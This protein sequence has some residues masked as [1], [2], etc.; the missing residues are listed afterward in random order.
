[1][2][3]MT[4]GM[5]AGAGSSLLSGFL[6]SRSNRRAARM[7]DRF[8]PEQVSTA[9]YDELYNRVAGANFDQPLYEGFQSSQ[10]GAANQ[11]RRMYAQMGNP[12]L[13][14]EATA[15]ERRSAQGALFGALGQSNIQRLGMLGNIQAART[16]IESQNVQ[17][18]NAARMNALNFRAGMAQNSPWAQAAGAL[19]GMAVGFGAQ[20]SGQQMMQAQR[21]ED[22]AFLERM[23]GQQ[24]PQ[25]LAPQMNFNPA[26]SSMAPNTTNMYYSAGAPYG[27]P[28]TS[29]N[30]G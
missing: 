4:I 24:R 10:R 18:R 1:M 27:I 23:F 19:G 16:G 14:A 8:T 26:A 25:T 12:A 13:A 17:A 30:L 22:M 21:T 29:F 5:I 2:D 7:M 6:Q 3:P 20:R 9:G 28:M 15:M 11:A